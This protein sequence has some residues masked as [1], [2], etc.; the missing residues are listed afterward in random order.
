MMNINLILLR[1]SEFL[2]NCH[3]QK[4]CK[5]AHLVR[6]GAIGTRS[7]FFDFY[8]LMACYVLAKKHQIPNKYIL[9]LLLQLSKQAFIYFE[10]VRYLIIRTPHAYYISPYT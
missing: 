8:N 9:I 5:V 6:P 4:Y 7:R 2:I 10:S 3:G 1:N